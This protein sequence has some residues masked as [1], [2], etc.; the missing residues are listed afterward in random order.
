MEMAG[1]FF[2][3]GGL[4]TYMMVSHILNLVSERASDP[5]PTRYGTDCNTQEK[6][7]GGRWGILNYYKY[8]QE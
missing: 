6:T 8:H 4:L 1:W 3:N 5:S 2:K 7:A